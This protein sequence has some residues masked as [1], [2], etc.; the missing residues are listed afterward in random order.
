VFGLVEIVMNTELAQYNK[1]ARLF[2]FFLGGE[3]A[4]GETKGR[5]GLFLLGSPY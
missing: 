3:S 5:R 4:E 2:D 1:S